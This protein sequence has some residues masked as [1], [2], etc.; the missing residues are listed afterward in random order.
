[1]EVSFEGLGACR[2]GHG[3]PAQLSFRAR[4]PALNLNCW[5]TTL[6]LFSL[7]MSLTVVPFATYVWGA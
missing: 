3:R 5:Q 2:Q 4:L 7:F 1:M 6:K